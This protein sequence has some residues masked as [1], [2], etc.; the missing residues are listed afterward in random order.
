[1]EII[2]ELVDIS[3]TYVL[4]EIEVYALRKI[5]MKIFRG[6]ILGIMGPSGS[7]KTTLL[8]LIGTLDKPDSGRIFIEGIDIG[9]LRESELVNLRR[10]T[11]GY[12]FQFYNLIPVLNALDNVI[13]PMLLAGVGREKRE[14][15]ATELLELVGLK[16]RMFHKPDELSGGEQ[17]RVAIARALV[18]APSIILADEPTGDLDQETGI[19]VV[20]QMRMIIEQE[21]RTLVIVTHD[22]TVL[23]YTT[24]V[25]N[26]KDGQIIKSN[27]RN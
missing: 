17:Q 3:K 9:S 8:N 26:L 25:L 21:K 6:E 22:P 5:N 23:K 10:K 24:R 27:N 1:M 15:R 11:I 20:K 13:L 2:V 19:E 16:K 4:G 14:R 12:I 7:G 18:N